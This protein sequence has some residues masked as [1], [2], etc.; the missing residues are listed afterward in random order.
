[1][2]AG[3]QNFLGD[4]LSSI[5]SGIKNLFATNSTSELVSLD[6]APANSTALASLSSML[7]EVKKAKPAADRANNIKVGPENQ[8]HIQLNARN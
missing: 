6:E 2:R 4:A 7:E 8:L 1:M 5:G 3:S